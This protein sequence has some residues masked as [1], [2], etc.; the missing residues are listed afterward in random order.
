MRKRRAGMRRTATVLAAVALIM[1]PSAGVAVAASRTGTGDRDVLDGTG[2]NEVISGLG[3]GDKLNGF[4]G[5][6]TVKGGD[7]VDEVSGGVGS[8]KVYGN[9]G[10]DYLIDAPDD[11]TSSTAAPAGTTRRSGTSRPS[12]T[13]STAVPDETRP[14]WTGWTWSTAA[15]SRGC[16][17]NSS[18]NQNREGREIAPP[19]FVYGLLSRSQ[20]ELENTLSKKPARRG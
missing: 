15:R 17:N 8:D 10:N 20:E 5:E 11:R 4:G 19:A 1:V 13:W 6:D 9:A 18:R 14:T 16:R 2:R 7:G 12:R 3:G